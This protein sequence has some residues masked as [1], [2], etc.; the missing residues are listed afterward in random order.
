MNLELLVPTKRRI[1]DRVDATLTLPA[2]LHFEKKKTSKNSSE[3]DHDWKAAKSVAFNRRGTYVAVV[4]ESGT[5]AVFDVPSRTICA[6]YRESEGMEEILSSSLPETPSQDTHGNSPVMTGSGRSFLSWSKRSRSILVGTSG[7][8][9]ARLIDTT[10]PFGPEECS[11]IEK[12]EDKDKDSIKGDEE[13][14]LSPTADSSEKKRKRQLSSLSTKEARIVHHRLARNLPT[15]QLKIADA[16]APNPGRRTYNLQ[17]KSAALSSHKRY[18]E[19]TFKFPHSVASTLQIHPKDSCAGIATLSDGS[20]V[21]FWVPITAWEDKPSTQFPHV[22][23]ATIFKSEYLPIACASFDPHG[24]KLYAAT[25]SGK[26]LGF[27]VAAFFEALAAEADSMPTLK[28]SFVI[29]VPGGALVQQVVV[30]RNG[31]SLLLNSADAAI[32]LYTT[33]DC[34]TTPE[35][36]DKPLRVFHDSSSQASFS[37][38]DFSG[39]GGIVLGGVNGA[40]KKYELYIWDATTGDLLDKLTGA[41]VAINSVAWHPT[42]SFLAIAANDGLVDVW[43]PRINWTAFAPDFQ[44]LTENVEYVECEDEFDIVEGTESVTNKKDEL[45]DED[46]KVDILSVDAVPAF[47]SDSEDEVDVFSFETKVRRIFGL[48]TN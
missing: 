43:G 40:D 28:P 19:L 1:P 16:V 11:M 33:K 9:K 46:A 21:A 10:H 45:K 36:I 38:C 20:L 24:D 15:R 14:R 42:R 35:E 7:Q 22:K 3:D 26:L 37:S 27:E 25:S 47:A 4:Y 34:W 29:H 17:H 8:E 23:I 30:S 32:R 6:L 39:D 44:A 31:A 2:S 13:D 48:Y 41:P 5:V 12:K 18:P